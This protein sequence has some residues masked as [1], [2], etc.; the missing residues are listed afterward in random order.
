MDTNIFFYYKTIRNKDKKKNKHTNK[1][2]VYLKNKRFK[3]I[4][5]LSSVLFM[6][7]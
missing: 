3:H 5:S 4:K 6:E 2:H 1:K 7:I